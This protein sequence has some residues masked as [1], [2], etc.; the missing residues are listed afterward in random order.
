M[1]SSVSIR[2]NFCIIGCNIIKA[3][4]KQIV[5]LKLNPKVALQLLITV[6]ITSMGFKNLIT[7]NQSILK[8]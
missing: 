8:S 4:L 5:N 2:Q 3:A 1:K 7:P 6:L